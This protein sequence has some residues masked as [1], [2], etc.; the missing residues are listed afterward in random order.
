MD[1]TAQALTAT[2]T[3]DEQASPEAGC[4][5]QKERRRNDDDQPRVTLACAA[6]ALLLSRL[7][8]G[9]SSEELQQWMKS[10]S[11]PRCGPN[12]ATHFSEPKKFTPQAYTEGA[13]F[14]PFNS[15]K[16]TQ[17][18]AAA[19]RAQPS[20]VGSDCARAGTRRKEALE[21]MPLDCDGHGRQSRTAAASL[22]R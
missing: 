15:V 19:T 22:W 16:L 21:A 13:T 5:C 11:A 6:A 1:A 3:T 20:S 12:V 4:G 10:N 7:L 9:R 18:L 17:A 2:S 8:W 14:D